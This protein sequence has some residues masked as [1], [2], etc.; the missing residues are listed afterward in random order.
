MTEHCP[1]HSKL[2]QDVGE[3]K[4]MVN[5][6][7]DGQSEFREA[8][9]GVKKQLNSQDKESAIDRTK[10]KPFFVGLGIV[11][12]ILVTKL[13]ETVWDLILKAIK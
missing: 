13:G 3:I 10:I 8:I 11:M 12:V 2:M 1:D 6:L 7:V 9:D 5:T 4:G